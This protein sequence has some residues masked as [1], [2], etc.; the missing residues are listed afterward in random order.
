MA[1]TEHSKTVSSRVKSIM[2]INILWDNHACMPLRPG[3]TDFLQELE[4]HRSSG[5]SAVALNVSMDMVPWPETFKM[6]GTFRTWIK[7]N[8]D[9]YI[10][11]KTA[12]DIVQAKADGKLAVFFDIE[13]AGA[14][15]DLPELVEPYYELGVRWMLIAYNRRNRLGTGIQGKDEGLTDYGKRVIDRMNEVGMI[16]C[17]SHTGERTAM[18]AIAYSADPVIFSHSNA[19]ALCSHPRNISDTLIKACASKGGTIGINGLGV[20]LSD[21]HSASA[22]KL[23]D[24]VDYIANLVGP[25]HVAIGLDFVFDTSETREFIEKYPKWFEGVDPNTPY[26]DSLPPEIISDV[27]DDLL[28]RGWS[29]QDLAGFLGQN[30]MRVAKRVW[31]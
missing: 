23:A 3:N 19:K 31:K 16:L 11:L 12:D 13:G 2:Q 10:L 14:V 21:D 8:S 9:K 5:F 17:C 6:L 1:T 26:P 30:L 4:R 7:Q 24:H 28:G 25:T 27:L 22:E 15:D 18:D 29:D 20:F